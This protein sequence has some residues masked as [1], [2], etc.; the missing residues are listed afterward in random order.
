MS[1]DFTPDMLD[2]LTANPLR[3]FFLFRGD[4]LT[5]SIRLWDGFGDLVWSGQTW[6]G[7]GWWRGIADVKENNQISSEG[8]DIVLS[9]VPQS[10]ISLALTEVSHSCRG[11]V[12]LGFF[13]EAGAIVEDPKVIFEGSLST[14]N[15]SQGEDT[16]ELTL[17]YD[18][19]LIV[20]KKKKERRY[21]HEAQQAMF[22]GD[23][24][25]E[26]VASL[27]DWSLWWGSKPKQT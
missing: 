1:R 20:L 27:K 26:Y 2:A 14:P 21:N 19:D 13:D 6:L 3:P 10:I 16:S 18:D 17:S 15:I 12:W 4:F 25:F 9:A 11:K 5:Q 23:R 8:M 22:P 7:N 24:G